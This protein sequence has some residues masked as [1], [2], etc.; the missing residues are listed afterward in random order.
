MQPAY[1]TDTA[2]YQ[3]QEQKAENAAASQCIIVGH[4]QHLAQ[5]LNG[6]GA[7]YYVL[8]ERAV[9]WGPK[10]FAGGLVAFA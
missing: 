5:G 7:G 10:A 9:D 8:Q 6:L 4:A 2:L 1:H 3:V